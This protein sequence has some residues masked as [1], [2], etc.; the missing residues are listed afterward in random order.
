MASH[1]RR[2]P[3]GLVF[4]VFINDLFVDKLHEV[5][6]AIYAD[7]CTFW[8][9]GTEL[10]SLMDI[11]QRMLNKIERWSSKRWLEFSASKTKAVVFT[12]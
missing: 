8:V 2:G 6:H 4:S 5:K 11:A 10:N 7:D 1:A 12:H 9:T 3:Q